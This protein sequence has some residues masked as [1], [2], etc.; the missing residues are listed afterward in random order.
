MVEF[1]LLNL[2]F[3]SQVLQDKVEV[4]HFDGSATLSTSW[5]NLVTKTAPANKWMVIVA[6]ALD[7]TVAG[8]L[9]I[10]IEGK[11]TLPET[12]RIDTFPSNFDYRP[13]Y[14]K[15]PPKNNVKVKAR[16]DTGTPTLKYSIL[17]FIVG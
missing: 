3:L 16:A 13:V 9:D 5:T 6:I 10:E 17:M 11:S 1:D 12:M 8:D 14:I 4:Q 2:S 7:N 15:V